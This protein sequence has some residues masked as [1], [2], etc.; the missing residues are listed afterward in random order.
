MTTTGLEIAGYSDISEVSRGG[1]ATIYRAVQAT[2]EREVAIKVLTGPADES[3]VRRF[4][5]ECTAIGSLSGHPNIVTVYEAGATDDGRLYMVME[6]LHGGSLADQLAGRGPFA[7]TE[8]VDLG[9][10]IAGA[11]E[12]AHRAGI[13][14]GDLK[15]EN[16]LLSRLGEPKVADFGLAFLADGHMSTSGGLTGTIVHA[17]PEVLSG[18]RPTVAS[19]IYS[20][21][22]TLSCLLAGRPPFAPAGEASIV[23]ILGRITRDPPPDLRPRGVPADICR[24][25]EQGLAKAPADRQQNLA[26]FGRQ[27]QAVQAQL[28]HTITPLPIESPEPQRPAAPAT[29]TTPTPR[30]RRRRIGPSMAV[31]VALLAFV[32][33]AAQL[34]LRAE[35][36][37]PVL[38]QDNFDAGQ[39][40]YEHDDDGATLA[41]DQGAYRILV[42]RAQGLILSDTSFRGGVYGE[43]LTALTDVSV[44]VRARAATPGA[45]FGL[46]CRS[47]VNGDRYQA[48]LRTDGEALLLKSAGG[49]V[50]TLARERTAAFGEG[51]YTDLRLDCT[52]RSTAHLSLFAGDLRVAEAEDPDAIVSG[53]V[54]MLAGAEEPPA[55]VRFED[56]VLLGRR[57][58]A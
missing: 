9:A 2:F 43:P 41:Y 5:R 27:L 8:V 16:I 37:L 46:F 44:R 1:F 13:V 33:A 17:A 35:K 29:R 47:T 49:Q 15:P 3:A 32:V 34:A 56:F 11:V 55:D 6:F 57:Q 18:D 28:G 7:P 48:V 24:V 26:Q 54:G 31:V 52:G 39:N 20:L 22:S 42:K 14:H 53:S 36:P 51:A 38:Y 25:I 50:Q 12:S 45:V 30:A 58:G 40:W 23:S 19:D 21:A 10:R 4:H